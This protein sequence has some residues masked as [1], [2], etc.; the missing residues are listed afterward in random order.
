[1]NPQPSPQGEGGERTRPANE[2][3][4]HLGD[5][6][7]LCTSDPSPGPARGL[8][9]T[10][11]TLFQTVAQLIKVKKFG[12]AEAA[13]KGFLT[14]RG[15]ESEPWMYVILA[16]CIVARKGSDQDLKQTLSFAAF[17]RLDN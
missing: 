8:V 7:A 11:A 12:D 5:R 4:P 17:L 16:E 9:K 1:M 14:Y 15:K 3:L 6:S 10:P 2:L 13:L